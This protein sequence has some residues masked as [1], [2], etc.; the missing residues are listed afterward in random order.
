MNMYVHMYV[1]NL[2]FKNNTNSTLAV[3]FLFLFFMHLT[4]CC[5]VFSASKDIN[6]PWMFLCLDGN[7]LCR[8][9]MT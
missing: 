3:L 6:L 9:T 4:E 2:V 5:I 7:L 1:C 8:K